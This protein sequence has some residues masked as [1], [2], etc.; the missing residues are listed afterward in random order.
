MASGTWSRRLPVLPRGGRRRVPDALLGSSST[1]GDERINTQDGAIL[2][3]VRLHERLHARSMRPAWAP[4]CAAPGVPRRLN[5]RSP[6]ARQEEHPLAQPRTGRIL[7][8]AGAVVP[9]VAVFAT[10]YHIDR[11]ASLGDPDTSSWQ[12][13]FRLRIAVLGGAVLIAISSLVA[14][15]RPVL[16]GRT[17]LG[18]VVA[19]LIVRRIIDPPSLDYAVTPQIGVYLGALGALAAAAG[20]LVDSGREVVEQR[21]HLAFWRSPAGELP[22]GPDAGDRA[23]HHQP[24]RG[25]SSGDAVDSTARELKSVAHPGSPA[26]KTD[27]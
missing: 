8:A 14:Q 4:R 10:W 18:L 1:L 13:V 25:T 21:P 23:A 24:R 5:H 19:A 16:I 6:I 2:P 26:T 15:T 12:T 17:L 20:G 22:A 9:A 27:R 3:E 7:S 11:P